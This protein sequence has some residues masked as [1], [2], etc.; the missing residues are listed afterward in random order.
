MGTFWNN[1]VRV[2][3]QR[4]FNSTYIDTDDPSIVECT[5]AGFLSDGEGKFPSIDWSRQVVMSNFANYV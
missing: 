1:N 3:G 2:K 5:I 4:E